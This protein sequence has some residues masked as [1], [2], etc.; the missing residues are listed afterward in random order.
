MA[1]VF[2]ASP[3]K[4]AGQILLFAKLLVFFFFLSYLSFASICISLIRAWDWASSHCLRAFWPVW[5]YPMLTFLFS[6]FSLAVRQGLQDLSSPNPTLL[7]SPGVEAW[8]PKRWTAREFPLFPR[9]VSLYV[10]EVPS[11][12]FE[13]QILS[14]A[15][16]PCFVFFFFPSKKTFYISEC[17]YLSEC[18]FTYLNVTIFWVTVSLVYHSNLIKGA[19]HVFLWHFCGF[20]YLQANLWSF[21]NLPW[22]AVWGMAPS[23]VCFPITNYPIIFIRE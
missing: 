20:L 14:T 11:S 22:S 3:T 21:W 12:W 15:L 18:N 13:L 7:T 16:L 9:L 10:S 2:M 19:S 6:P 17:N 5:S 8:S 4:H 1:W 23:L